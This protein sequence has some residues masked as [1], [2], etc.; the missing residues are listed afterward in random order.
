VGVTRCRAR[1][2]AIT[3]PGANDTEEV[4]RAGWML[5]D[6]AGKRF[7]RT[8]IVPAQQPLTITMRECSMP[9]NNAGDD[10]S[11]LDPQGQI[12]HHVSY[13]ATQGA[14]GQVVTFD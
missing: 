6:R 8:G 11:L 5:R 2:A 7:A 1:V 14:S 10:V 4:N 13:S 12:R 9:L 3:T